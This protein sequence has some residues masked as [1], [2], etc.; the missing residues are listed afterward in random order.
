M[1]KHTKR[2]EIWDAA[3]RR[4][5]NGKSSRVEDIAG[6]TSLLQ[7]DGEISKVLDT[8]SDLGWLSKQGT[9]V[10]RWVPG[11]QFVRDEAQ[12]EES[13]TAKPVS[14]AQSLSNSETYTA[15]VDRISSSGNA[16]VSL[17]SK[18][19]N[20]MLNL[21]PI[22]SDAVGEEVKFSPLNGTWAE[23]LTEE[24]TYNGYSPRDGTSS[25]GSSG[26]TSSSGSSGSTSSHLPASSSLSKSSPL[27]TQASGKNKLI[28]NK[29]TDS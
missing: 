13:N 20:Q 24:Y 28:N 17:P 7:A 19:N 1:G 14:E 29:H 9:Q 23:C 6:Q 18:L 26:S 27:K 25:S 15:E 2:D 4:A 21:G 16:I 11:P 12:G 3:I 22:N 5:M 10:Y 8:M